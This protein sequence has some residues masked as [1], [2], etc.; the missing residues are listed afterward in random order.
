MVF[1]LIAAAFTAVSTALA[2]IG[3]AV[4]SFATNVL[5]T[6]AP[7]LAKGLEA[8]TNVVR[9]AEVISQVLGVLKPGETASG[10]GE[11][12]LQAAEQGITPQGFD[13]HDDYLDALR[14]FQVDPGKQHDPFVTNVSG[15]ALVSVAMDAKLNVADGTSGR[16]WQLV[17]ADGDYF[18]ADKIMKLVQTGQN[19]ADVVDYYTGKMGGAESLQ[20]ENELL[21]LDKANH[22]STDENT[23]RERMYT[24]QERVQAGADAL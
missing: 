22:P 9:V 14:K 13:N 16:L 18:T 12:A 7:Y 8:I 10:M 2:T 11:R 24:A 20:T 19:I 6:L 5:P 17:A 4:A 23:L 21:K 1:P 15:L 3:P